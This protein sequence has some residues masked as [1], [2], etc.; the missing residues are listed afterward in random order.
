MPHITRKN[1]LPKNPAIP[2]PRE[3]V[4]PGN[5]FYTYINGNWLH[6]VNMPSYLSSYGVSEEIENI[7]DNELLKIINDAKK[8]V[9]KTADKNIPHTEYLIGSLTESV[10]NVSSQQLNLKILREMVS[11]LKCIRDTFDVAATIGD[12]IKHR[13]PTSLILSVAPMETETKNLRL[14]LGPGSLGLPDLSY[15]KPTAAKSRIIRAY[16]NLLKRIGSDFNVPDLENNYGTEAIIAGSIY[17]S[18]SDEEIMMK[19]SE[20]R[21]KYKNIPWDAFIESSLGWPPSKFNNHSIVV[22]STHY[23]KALNSWFTNFPIQ[24]WKHLFTSQLIL[25]MLPLLPPPYDNWEF[26]L[27]GKRMRGQSEKL[28]QRLLALHLVKQWLGASL[29]SY[30]VRSYVPPSIKE[31]AYLLANEI[32]QSAIEIA[33]STQWLDEA[34]RKKA[35]NKVRSIYLG[36]AYPD[37]IIKDKKTEL[38]KEKLVNN[39]LKLGKLDFQNEVKKI[40]TE[41]KPKEW[42]DDVFAVNAYY[43]NEANR[44]ILPAGILRWPFFHPDA[45]DG[46]NFGGIGATIGHEISHAFDNDGKD[47]DEEGNKKPWWSRAEEMRYHKKTDALIELY[48]KTEYFGQHLNGLLTLSENIADLGGLHIA[49]SALKKRLMRKNVGPLVMKKE[50]CD[51]FTSFAVSWRT[52][53]KKQKAFQSLFMDVHAPPPSRVNNIVRQFDEWYECFHIKPGNK[54]YKDP[55]E[56]IR[57]F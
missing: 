27:F 1:R 31:N 33:G 16:I 48:N 57:I 26:E 36:V 55:L 28:P 17:I 21:L 39:I 18:K 46:W 49:L 2:P 10:V 34:T 7:I 13:I 19:G 56:R 8:S 25:Y 53:E 42:D 9:E 32:K 37:T 14:I 6:H 12:F 38:Y 4:H 11:T 45:S 44:L 24:T 15:Y 51:F 3:S 23:L 54:L 29:G 47:Y 50:L 43:Y 41:L 40:G 20:L 30:F 35:A 5:D 52:K 22:M